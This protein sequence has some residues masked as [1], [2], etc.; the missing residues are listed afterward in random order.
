[1][2]R[3]I[4]IGNFNLW[5]IQTGRFLTRSTAD[6]TTITDAGYYKMFSQ[7]RV[8]GF[9]LVFLWLRSTRTASAFKRAASD[10]ARQVR[11]SR[12]GAP[13]GDAFAAQ[14]RPGP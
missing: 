9:G 14:K 3:Q 12:P 2:S 8:A 1:M 10:W 11:A 13:G 5:I 4:R 6:V 7:G